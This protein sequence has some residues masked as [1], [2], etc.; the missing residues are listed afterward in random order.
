[1]LRGCGNQRHSIHAL[2]PV[3][4]YRGR[5]I[6]SLL[7]AHTWTSCYAPVSRGRAVAYPETSVD[8]R[9]PVHGNK[10][11]ARTRRALF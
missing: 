6:G 4:L 2:V 7:P 8:S 9:Q 10:K 5:R 11:L 3:R 1:M